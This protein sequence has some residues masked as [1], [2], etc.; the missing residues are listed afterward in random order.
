MIKSTQN[1]HTDVFLESF[2]SLKRIKD[3]VV[4]DVGCGDGYASKLFIEYGAKQVYSM[5]PSTTLLD[6]GRPIWIANT[7]TMFTKDWKDI[8]DLK[9]KFDIIW[10]HHVAEHV[11]DVF[12][13]FRNIFNLLNDTGEMWMA[14]PNMA[15]HAIFS[16]GHIHNFQAAQLIDVLKRCGFAVGDV[17]IWVKG[18]QIRLRIPKKG[19]TDYP[20]PMLEAI[21]KTGRCPAD[22]LTN[23]NWKISD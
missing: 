13:F 6:N 2:N 17:S 19:N 9:I 16:P 3:S 7:S 4:L 23:W 5:D 8:E 21:R 20:T 22:V 11:E 12:S 14:C 10:H 1:C 18:G 15:Q